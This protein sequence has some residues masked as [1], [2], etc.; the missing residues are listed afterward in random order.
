MKAAIEKSWFDE[1]AMGKIWVEAYSI[2]VP[3]FTAVICTT[4][5]FAVAH[6]QSVTYRECLTESCSTS[7]HP[8]ALH[9]V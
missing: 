4:F 1:Y 6:D 8:S 3:L 5:N 2:I 9:P 7:P